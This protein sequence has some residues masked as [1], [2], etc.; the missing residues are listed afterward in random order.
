MST[1]LEKL[2]VSL[3][4]DIRSYQN[5]MQ[6][7]VGVTNRQ[8]K[9][10]EDRYKRM[11]QTLSQSLAAPIAGLGAALSTREVLQYA[12][13]WTRA[14]NMVRAA[15]QGAGVQTRSL[16]DL[17]KGAD[18]ARTSLETYVDL[19]AKLIRASAGVAKSEQEVATATDVVAKAMKAGGAST[20]EQQSAITQLGQALASGVLQGDELRSLRENAPVIADAIAKEMNTTIGGLKKLGSEGKITSDKVFR[21]ILAAQPQIEAQFK[22]TNQTIAE[23]FTAIGNALTQYIGTMG[24]S[25][26]LTKTVNAIL[27]AVAGNL[28]VVADAAAAAGVI[29]LSRYVPAMTR[30]VGAQALVAA[31][32]PFLLLATGAAAATIAIAEFGDQIHPVA[33]D[34]ANLQDYSATLWESISSGASSAATAA[35]DGF[36]SIINGISDMIGGVQVSWADVGS[37]VKDEINS[38]IGSVVAL[39]EIVKANFTVLPNVIGAAA[40]GAMNLMISAI[41]AG[42][43]KIVDVVNGISSAVNGAASAVGLDSFAPTLN[44]VSFDRFQNDYVAA[45]KDTG[46]AAAKAIGDALSTDYLGDFA[47][48]ANIRALDRRQQ[49]RDARDSQTPISTAGYGNAPTAPDSGS[50]S[51]KKGKKPKQNDY[52][53]EIEQITRR[54]AAL[55]AETEA[56]AG[57]NPL[58]D[59]YGYAVAKAKSLQDLET[60]A[61]EAGIK[62]TAK[63][64]AAMEQLSE[65]YAQAVVAQ[66]QL[67]E[68]QQRL[69]DRA[70]EWQDLSENT[71]K[72][73]VQDLIEGKSAAD[74]LADAL[75]RVGDK[76]IDMAFDNLFDTKTGAFGGIGNALAT[77]FSG[78]SAAS[79]APGAGGIVPALYHNGGVVGF[80]GASAGKAYSPSLWANAPRYHNGGIAGLKPNEVP[81]ILLRG[82]RVSRRG[83]KATGDD[84]HITVGVSADNNGNLLPFVESVSRDQVRRSQP[85]TVNRAVKTVGAV[86]R[87]SRSYLGV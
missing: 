9:Q 83:E 44:K 36:L 76:L 66:A 31:T 75:G 34:M 56:Q 39:Y 86:N 48:N 65:A 73:F 54:T 64:R 45:A 70:E 29:L 55:K 20:Q 28:N 38:I 74:A 6:K 14:G 69:K 37:F 43:N 8:V 16:D 85:A 57:V 68:A 81:A 62:V 23:G 79:V 11:N 7:A 52:E 78:S 21:A 82:E 87:E 33:G 46:A 35:S 63:Q 12:D 19:Y 42:I 59:D 67:E 25:V 60:A 4:A 15:G 72:G 32:N 80:G 10:I 40:V 22:S 77:L 27:G 53:K 49:Q 3:S 71:A 61:K 84:M 30:V 51:G 1:D 17:R 41:E 18:G 5:A 13:A 47:K 50:G 24:Q 26:G 58:I 2:V